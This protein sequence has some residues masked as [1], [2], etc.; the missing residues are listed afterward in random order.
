MELCLNCNAAH[1]RCAGSGHRPRK[2]HC[3]KASGQGHPACQH[4]RVLYNEDRSCLQLIAAS[5]RRGGMT[6]D[7]TSGCVEALR[8][9]S[10]YADVG[11]RKYKKSLPTHEPSDVNHLRQHVNDVVRRGRVKRLPST[12][13]PCLIEKTKRPLSDQHHRAKALHRSYDKHRQK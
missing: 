3:V 5:A 6:V 4:F 11:R 8:E 13:D 10:H 9:I 7:S 1:Q 12:N 2:Q